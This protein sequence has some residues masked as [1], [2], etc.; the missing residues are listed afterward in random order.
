MIENTTDKNSNNIDSITSE[1]R[2]MSAS[3]K[4]H[5]TKVN[6]P[7]TAKPIVRIPSAQPSALITDHSRDP[8]PIP[9]HTVQKPICSKIISDQVNLKLFIKM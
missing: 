3:S 5:E 2:N 6:R 9:H 8:Q 4:S 7:P 1:T